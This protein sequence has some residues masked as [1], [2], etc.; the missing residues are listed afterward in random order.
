MNGG[1]VDSNGVLFH[2]DRVL[3]IP[4]EEFLNQKKAEDVHM[5]D[6]GEAND[7]LSDRIKVKGSSSRHDPVC[8]KNLSELKLKNLQSLFKNH[9]AEQ[10]QDDE[11]QDSS[12]LKSMHQSKLETMSLNAERIKYKQLLRKKCKRE[13]EGEEQYMGKGSGEKETLVKTDITQENEASN[14]KW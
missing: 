13:F 6:E 4:K 7:I 5:K 9:K 8:Y 1:P 11:S 14:P 2:D 12:V 10:T 3:I